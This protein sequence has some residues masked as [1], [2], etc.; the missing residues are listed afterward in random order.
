MVDISDLSKKVPPK[1]EDGPAAV[2]GEETPRRPVSIRLETVYAHKKLLEE[3]KL[4][5]V[6]K[7]KEEEMA[8]RKA[9]RDAEAKARAKR[10]Q[11]KK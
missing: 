3:E 5:G 10:V 7:K 11:E 2:K 9:Q 8:K 6:E 4:K 1:Q